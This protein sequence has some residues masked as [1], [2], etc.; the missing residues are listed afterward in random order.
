MIMNIIAQSFLTKS[1][2]KDLVNNLLIL[3]ARRNYS[4]SNSAAFMGTLALRI[5]Q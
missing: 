1:H 5:K 4:I 3:L 2:E